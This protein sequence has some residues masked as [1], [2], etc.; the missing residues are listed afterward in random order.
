[1]EIRRAEVAQN[2]ARVLLVET[3]ER[4]LSN[5]EFLRLI[6]GKGLAGHGASATVEVVD[7][8]DEELLVSV[9]FRSVVCSVA[10]IE[11]ILS[12]T[13][14]PSKKFYRSEGF[15]KESRS[16]GVPLYV[17]YYL[18]KKFPEATVSVWDPTTE[19]YV[20]YV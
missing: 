6:E 15:N 18:K 4:R 3:T 19:R 11:E 1:M 8:S 7:C 10:E 17:A 20:E 12:G 2:N 9:G 16:A 5:E 14:F 13:N